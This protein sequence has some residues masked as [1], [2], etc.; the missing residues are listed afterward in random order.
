ML[1]VTFVTADGQRRVLTVDAD[2]S[3][4]KCALGNGVPGIIAECGGAMMCATCH[5]YIDERDLAR[6]GPISAVENEMLDCTVAERRPES[7]LSCQLLM[8]PALDGLVVHVP[9]AE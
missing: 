8:T 1:E 4:M 5:V 3:V 6:M 2:V 9:S 7:R